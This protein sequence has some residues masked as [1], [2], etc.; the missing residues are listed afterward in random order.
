M[1]YGFL[2]LKKRRSLSIRIS[3][4]SLSPWLVGLDS[5]RVV[6]LGWATD[7]ALALGISGTDELEGGGG[8]GADFLLERIF[9]S[10]GGNPLRAVDSG[11]GP[12]RLGVL[13]GA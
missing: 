1:V 11:L 7:W 6:F 3:L 5:E 4:S 12:V 2:I 10:C 13:D 8:C 9:G